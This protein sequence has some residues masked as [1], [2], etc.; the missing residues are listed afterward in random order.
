[1]RTKALAAVVAAGALLGGCYRAAEPDRRGPLT[2][3]SQQDSRDVAGPRVDPR[4]RAGGEDV[5]GS[6]PDLAEGQAPVSVEPE[7]NHPPPER[8]D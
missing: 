4:T 6:I 5:A 3:A 8:G 1:M 2:R 7:R